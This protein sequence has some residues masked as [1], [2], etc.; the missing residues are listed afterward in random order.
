MSQLSI[1]LPQDFPIEASEILHSSREVDVI[2]VRSCLAVTTKARILLVSGK[3]GQEAAIFGA[4]L[5]IGSSPAN[6]NKPSVIFQL[7][8]VHRTFHYD[9]DLVPTKKPDVEDSSHLT[10][11]LADS[12][13]VLSERLANGSLLAQLRDDTNLELCVDAVEVLSFEGSFIRVNTFG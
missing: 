3:A 13:L 6:L 5:P 9:G 2:C 8:P 4:Y 11:A 12:T 10:F 7:A 1:S